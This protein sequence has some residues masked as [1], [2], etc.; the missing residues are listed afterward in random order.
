MARVAVQ[1]GAK[2]VIAEG[3]GALADLADSGRLPIPFG[4]HSG[5]CGVCQVQVLEGALAPPG[6]LEEAILEGFQCPEDVRLAC[7]AFVEGDVRLR[8][9]SDSVPC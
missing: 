7:Q 5:R 9:V 2:D 6:K 3:E 4:C 8:A 1:K